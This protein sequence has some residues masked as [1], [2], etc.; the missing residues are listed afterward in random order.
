MGKDLLFEIGTEE[1]PDGVVPR[2]LNDLEL[3]A[4][5]KLKANRIDHGEIKAMGTPRRLVLSVKD[6]AERQSDLTE[7][8]VGPSKKSAYDANG[9]PTAASIGFARAHGVKPEELKRLPRAESVMF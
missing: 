4:K 6:I 2:A 1:V 8:K 9:N 3:L 5:E 7:E